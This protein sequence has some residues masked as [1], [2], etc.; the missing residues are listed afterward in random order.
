M[1][2]ALPGLS[3]DLNIGLADEDS[4]KCSSDDSPDDDVEVL[5]TVTDKRKEQLAGWDLTEE[6]VGT[7][8]WDKQLVETKFFQKDL[9]GQA[10]AKALGAIAKRDREIS[11]IAQDIDVGDTVFFYPEEKYF[12]SKT[13]QWKC[14]RVPALVWSIKDLR[15]K[16]QG[17][18]ESD[19]RKKNPSTTL[20][21]LVTMQG[22]L[23]E[24]QYI[25]RM[26]LVVPKDR[27]QHP[28]FH[29]L[30]AQ[31]I[32]L[33]D[34]ITGP[35]LS[36]FT[37]SKLSVVEVCKQ[38][39]LK[40]RDSEE[41]QDRKNHARVLAQN[42]QMSNP[43]LA[44]ADTLNEREIQLS[45]KEGLGKDKKTS[46]TTTNRIN[47]TVLIPSTRSRFKFISQGQGS[48]A[49]GTGSP[50]SKRKL[51]FAHLI[52]GDPMEAKW[53]PM[54]EGQSLTTHEKK[55]TGIKSPGI[56]HKAEESDFDTQFNQSGSAHEELTGSG[57]KQTPKQ[58][59]SC[60]DAPVEHL[61]A[62]LK[63]TGNTCCLNAP[64]VCEFAFSYNTQQRHV[65]SSSICKDC[66]LKKLREAVHGVRATGMRIVDAS[67]TWRALNVSRIG[68]QEDAMEKLSEILERARDVSMLVG[69]ECVAWMSELP[70][71]EGRPSNGKFM[72]SRTMSVR[73]PEGFAAKEV[74]L[75]DA[76]ACR[77]CTGQHRWVNKQNTLEGHGQWELVLRPL[78]N[79]GLNSQ[80]VIKMLRQYFM[81]ERQ[82]DNYKYDCKFCGPNQNEQVTKMSLIMRWPKKLRLG[83]SR[84]AFNNSSGGSDALGNPATDTL[85]MT[86]AVDIPLTFSV[87]D[88]AYTWDRS[89][90]KKSASE[91]LLYRLKSVLVHDE[92]TSCRYGHYWA[93]VW[94]PSLERWLRV[95][96][97]R[98]TVMPLDW[99]PDGEETASKWENVRNQAGMVSAVFYERDEPEIERDI[100][101]IVMESYEY[102]TTQLSKV[103]KK[104]MYYVDDLVCVMTSE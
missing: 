100:S 93:F 39:I 14:A 82:G 27:D 102:F 74:F 5:E 20:Y 94:R 1:L 85:I 36:E 77:K 72:S 43:E 21:T 48:L 9:V 29:E 32:K 38:H 95:D 30:V 33:K 59:K 92:S 12:S 75:V 96:D 11:M 49:R 41:E 90:W 79:D 99:S 52:P 10:Q 87:P 54:K 86:W 4:D 56:E 40:A 61:H 83:I 34:C 53:T 101:D 65:C 63:N 60:R 73:Q 104:R 80:N 42:L 24:P 26:K 84:G 8:R 81:P 22:E 31:Y 58:S 18:K 45:C 98:V 51:H 7:Y 37:L 17:Q 2:V 62:G 55:T 70:T 19:Q 103:V 67:E 68:R 47:S 35:I 91:G 57:R 50:P 88:E 6:D 28:F 3:I 16:K 25:D 76:Y 89:A 23:Q 44:T 69:R 13:V 15:N 66:V 78:S 64:V 46:T 97:H 71:C